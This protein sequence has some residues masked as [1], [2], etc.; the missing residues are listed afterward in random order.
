MTW[1][2]KIYLGA[3]EDG[4]FRYVLID[5]G[6][7]FTD[8][9]AVRHSKKEDGMA[10]YKSPE[11]WTGAEVDTQSDIYSLGVV[12]YEMLTGSA[13]FP[14]FWIKGILLNAGIGL[15]KAKKRQSLILISV[16]V[17][18]LKKQLIDCSREMKFQLVEQAHFK[19]FRRGQWTGFW[20]AES[21][22]TFFYDGLWKNWRGCTNSNNWYPSHWR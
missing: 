15:K 2:P 3:K 18:R 16:G 14:I 20:Q 1:I 4:S 22:V 8:P 21:W 11:K 17:K 7:S 13:P 12:I 19:M 10:E 9:D 6:L 5:F